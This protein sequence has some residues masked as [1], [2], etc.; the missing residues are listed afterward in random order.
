MD[1]GNNKRTRIRLISALG[2]TVG[3]FNIATA[4]LPTL[5]ASLDKKGLLIGEQATLK[6]KANFP[7]NGYTVAWFAPPDSLSHFELVQAGNIDTLRSNGTV[8]LEQTLVFTSF[9]SGQW[10]TPPLAVTFQQQGLPKP[11]TL[12]AETILY[13][14]G[15]MPDSTADIRDIKP[16]IDADAEKGWPW[17]LFLLIG[18]GA[19][20]VLALLV[21]LLYRWIRRGAAKTVAIGAQSAYQQAMQ[22]LAALQSLNLALPSECRLYHTRLSQLFK[23]YMGHKLGVPLRNKTTGDTLLSLKEVQLPPAMLTSAGSA[24][25]G[26][27]AVKFAKFMPDADQCAV[28]HNDI[29]NIIEQVEKQQ[30]LHA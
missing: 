27:D 11:L 21:W 5:T 18:L 15:F 8:Q 16:I 24:L 25:R 4:Q 22:Q 28:W 12:R 3:L 29:K 1:M 26:C 10:K 20:A 13:T 2:L 23:A 17:R 7:D 19:V 14:V 6:V 30:V 9:D